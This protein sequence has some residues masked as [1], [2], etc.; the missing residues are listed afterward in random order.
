MM[1][2]DTATKPIPIGGPSAMAPAAGTTNSLKR[3]L[4]RNRSVNEAPACARSPITKAFDF[5]PWGRSK[6]AGDKTQTHIQQQQQQKQLQKA[7]AAAANAKSANSNA[8]GNTNSN[9]SNSN[10]S[11][12]TNAGADKDTGIHYHRNIFRSGG[13]LIRDILGG[14]KLNK[15]KGNQE[16]ALKKSNQRIKPKQVVAR[17]KSLDIHELIN[18][19][20]NELS[21][22]K[23]KNGRK[24][25]MDDT[26]IENIMRAKEAY[27]QANEELLDDEQAG[28][29][30]YVDETDESEGTARRQAHEEQ[31]ASDEQLHCMPS[32]SSGNN[33]AVAHAPA[34][35]ILFNDEDIV[36]LIKKELPVKR[37]MSKTK[38]KVSS[39]HAEKEH[40][41]QQQ[42]QQL[43][44]YQQY[45]QQQQQQGR[46]RERERDRERGR[47]RHE[48]SESVLRARLKFKKLTP[49]GTPLP[50][51]RST[52]AQ[53]LNHNQYHNQCD[54]NGIEYE[55]PQARNYQQSRSVNE[56]S[57]TSASDNGKRGILQRQNTSPALIS[58]AGE[59]GS[60]NGNG[61]GNVGGAYEEDAP[62]H[63]SPENR[64]RHHQ[65]FQRGEQRV[66]LQ[67]RKSFTG[68]DNAQLGNCSSSSSMASGGGGGSGGVSANA[69]IN[70]QPRG[71]KPRKKLSF[72][73]PVADKPRVRRRSSPLQRPQS[74]GAEGRDPSPASKELSNRLA[75]DDGIIANANAHKVSCDNLS[76]SS[77][78][79]ALMSLPD[80]RNFAAQINN[81]ALD[82]AGCCFVDNANLTM[83]F[84]SQAMRIVRTVGQAFEVCH[85]FNLHKNSLD[86][87]DE[88]S[89]VSSELLDVERISV[90]QLTDDEL[91]KKEPL[92]AVTDI[93]PPQ[94]P[95]HLELVPQSSS[96]MRK[97]PSLLTA[98]EDN[99]P[100]TPSSP[101]HEISKL[102]DQLEQQ[103][104]QTRQALGQLMLV[105]EQLI[106][107]TNAR[108][109]A[110]ARTQQ[111]LQ[112]N[113]ELL[114][115]LASLGAYN[116]QQSAGLTSANIGMAPQLQMLL[117]ATGN[118]N[119][120]ATINQQ[121]N[122][123]GSINQ[124]LTSLSH[125][126]SGLNQQSQNI[127]NFQNINAAAAAAAQQ[128]QQHQ[129]PSPPPVS[130]AQLT[131]PCSA[132]SLQQ[133][134]LHLNIATAANAGN[135][136]NNNNSMNNGGGSSSPFPTMNQL[137]SISNQLQQ[138]NAQ[139]TQSQQDAL[140]KDLF[141]VNQE[142]LNRLQA[143]NLGAGN[144]NALTLNTGAPMA[145]AQQ[146]PSPRNSFFFVNPM[147]CSPAN[148]NNNAGNFNFL[149]SPSML[150]G[151][152]TPSPMST[153]TRNSYT[154]SPQLQHQQQ[155]EVEALQQQLSSIDQNL[156]CLID[157]QLM[158]PLGGSMMST[159]SNGNIAAGSPSGT[160]E[161]SRSSSTL[162]SAS[163]SSP[164]IRSAGANN[165][166]NEPRF[167]T[168]MLKVTD[169]AGN[170]TNQRK[171][172]ATPSFIQRSTSE[173]VP[174]RSQIMSQVQRTAW[175]RHT[176]K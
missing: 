55:Q 100:T 56:S 31:R 171:L 113:R 58:L 78:S 109:E 50:K 164:R 121:I 117:Q 22:E 104:I 131:P 116:E 138:L 87:N 93:K 139:A 102:K 103:A 39:N 95:N 101:S 26:F 67:R 46:E 108:I 6:K 149:S 158:K 40:Q 155:Q 13:G 45:Q 130:A 43:Q 66:Q 19:V 141:Q 38:R 41:Q 51:R 18:T 48:R 146:T 77:S 82:A 75:V 128:Q 127:Q 10:A 119:N 150:S 7:N 52:S 174:N 170:V 71:E 35:H 115:H 161:S 27:R 84:E 143:L 30:R 4:W 73:E 59:G 162:D 136:N 15:E 169:E 114:E 36:Y 34:R 120:L 90:Q 176:T 137:Q 133:S 70:E 2:H 17:N 98:D 28:D 105:R 60:G 134:Q 91:E 68:Y 63:Q 148:N 129:Q 85:K 54:Y 23:Q 69:P 172:S 86:H 153:L 173:K 14:D 47:D 123:L 154:H 37:E 96:N 107:E 12:N 97:S 144:T 79:A 151:Q 125:Q 94:R 61:N 24:H 44:Q 21:A 72:R 11:N 165:N 32:G 156:N 16:L 88:R 111:L 159:S 110:Q 92:T 118:N 3:G 81:I 106:S 160:R 62:H 135:A 175:A 89:D 5:L 25:F 20:E 33:A 9:T 147:S 122:S 132:A 157:E 53:M 167:N 152:L 8:A 42:Q 112:Q 76:A 57:T 83:D 163:P 99:T 65:L 29:Y 124:Q 126:L 64:R 49:D 74:A 166:N 1:K 80:N 142:L 168:V 145:S 140:S